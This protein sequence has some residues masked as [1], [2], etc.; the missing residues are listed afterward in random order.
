M[1]KGND[2]INFIYVN[3]AFISQVLMLYYFITLSNIKLNWAKYRCNPLYMP[4]SDDIEKDFT[5]C[6][7]TM[8]SSFMGYLL[9]PLQYITSS[10][11]SLGGVFTNSI[12]DIR[13]IISTIRTFV[14]SIIENIFGVFLNLIIEF[15]KIIIGIK[16]MVGKLVGIMVTMMYIL[17][18]SVKTM[19]SAWNGPSGQMVRALGHC[20]HPNTELK[21][22]DGKLVSMKDLKLGDILEDGSVVEATML[23]DN[24]KHREKLYKIPR[25][26][27][28][29]SKESKESNN[30]FPSEYIY[31]TES[32][33]VFC[34][35]KGRF[36]QVRD[37]KHAQ[38]QE[39]VQSSHFSCII[40]N[41]HKIKIGDHLFWDYE[42][43][44]LN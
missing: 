11:G 12:N 13:N 8:Q 19:G 40:T 44:I 3:V 43:W 33:Y 6:V 16:D 14:T 39:H 25:F 15:Q 23:I 37:Y 4:F 18:G 27:L 10:L 24:S 36:I 17:D 35:T 38:L 41:T 9:Q 29:E 34:K 20:F 42:D 22:L 28:I 30:S 21:L 1:P 32:H 2:W 7:Q 5:Y 26:F 31:V